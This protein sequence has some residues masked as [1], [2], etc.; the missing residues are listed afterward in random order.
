MTTT[1]AKGMNGTMELD[2]AGVRITRKGAGTTRVPLA[3][4]RS[5]E[6]KKG[7]LTIGYLR[8]HTGADNDNRK[9]RNKTQALLREPHTVT[10]QWTANKEWETLAEALETA[11]AAQVS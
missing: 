4:I 2:A 5:I 11:V 10:F 9:A 3:S 7:G 8:L 6:H 1:T